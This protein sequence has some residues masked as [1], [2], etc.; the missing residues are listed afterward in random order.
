L[1][2][3][4]LTTNALMLSLGLVAYNVMRMCGQTAS[5]EI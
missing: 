4:T 3:K 1:S 5:A 2:S